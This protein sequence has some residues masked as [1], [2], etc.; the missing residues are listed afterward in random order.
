LTADE[1]FKKIG[2]SDDERRELMYQMKL[3]RKRQIPFDIKLGKDELPINWWFSIEDNFP[4]GEDYLVQLA[5]KL[6]SVT[7]HAAGC[8]RIWSKLGWIYGKRRNRLGLDK[9][10]N[11]YK[12]SS[13]Y[14]SHAKQE[15]PYYS[16]EKTSD[17]ICEIL[18]NAHL[19]PDEDLIDTMEEDI[20]DIS[21]TE[22]D[23]YGEE[24]NLIISRVLNLNADEFINDLDEIIEDS[25]LEENSVE[26][27]NNTQNE[28]NIEWDPIAEADNIVNSM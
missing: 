17:Q 8:E 20:D 18:V 6:L 24:D 9:V 11:M 26:K 10:E 15:L 14:H 4:K 25:S 21:D 1:I 2:K 13:Y 16:M 28:V 12:L 27:Q 19:Y 7:P 22:V 5:T 23:S 3:Y